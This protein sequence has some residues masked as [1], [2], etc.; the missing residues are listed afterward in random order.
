[1]ARIWDSANGPDE[2]YAL[3]NDVRQDGLVDAASAGP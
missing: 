2:A 1:M 3:S